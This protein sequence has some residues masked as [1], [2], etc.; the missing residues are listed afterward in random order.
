MWV[1]RVDTQ[2]GPRRGEQEFGIEPAENILHKRV[3]YQKSARWVGTVPR[4]VTHT[5]H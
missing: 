3:E 5:E 4:I 2:D 1:L